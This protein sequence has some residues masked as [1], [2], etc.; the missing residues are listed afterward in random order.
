M[1]IIIYRL[2]NEDFLVQALKYDMSVDQETYFSYMFPAV[3]AMIFGMKL[4]LYRFENESISI[5]TIIQ[6]LRNQLANKST[7]GIV[8][9]LIGLSS[10][11]LQVYVPG[12]LGY[13]MYLISKLFYVGIF[14]IYYS[15]IKNKFIYIFSGLFL[16]L[17]QTILTGIFGEL[18]YTLILGF[19]LLALG[20]K[21]SFSRKVVLFLVGFFVIFILQSIKGDYRKQTWVNENIDKSNVFVTLLLKSIQSPIEAF[22]KETFF[23][24]VVRTNQGMI[25]G[26]VMDYIP[27]HTSFFDGV[28]IWKS[29]ASAFVP[30]FLWP[31]KP[32]AG[33]K[34][35]MLEFT[36]LVIEGYSM[37]VSPFGEAYA[38]FNIFGGII[39]M[40][41]YGIIFNLAYTL[42]L[43]KAQKNYTL[44]LWFPAI[45]INSI[46]IETDTLMTV[47]SLLKT[48]L[49]I[50]L[51]YWFS[52]RFLRIKL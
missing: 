25:I 20:K 8:F 12:E 10:T 38:N 37:N 2:Y 26:K 29:I 48:L 5:V 3:M 11:F 16:L 6:S 49:F 46:Q 21:V 50:A 9:M 32:I 14:Y 33:G 7:L 35:N 39:Y 52:N 47:N 23:P 40:F 51:V 22:D 18:V 28:T 1:P 36:G 43:I 41:F 24:F 17:I 27:S 45:F 4:P 13:V 15:N 30:R 42:L 44:I 31:D 34:L 19:L